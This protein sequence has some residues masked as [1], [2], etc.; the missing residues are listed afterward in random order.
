MQITALRQSAAPAAISVLW[1]TWPQSLSARVLDV[2]TC[3]TLSR[4]AAPAGLNTVDLLKVASSALNIGPQH[5]MQVAER[6]YTRQV[7]GRSCQVTGKLLIDT[8][9]AMGRLAAQLE[10]TSGCMFASAVD[11]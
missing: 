6:L 2:Q 9:H 11:T 7:H 4:H 10:A 1:Q 3:S 5:A 8:D